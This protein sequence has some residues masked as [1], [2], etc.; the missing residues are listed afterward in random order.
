MDLFKY[1]ATISFFLSTS[2]FIEGLHIN[3]DITNAVVCRLGENEGL[4]C[5]NRAPSPLTVTSP[6]CSPIDPSMA[7]KP[8]AQNPA[9]HNSIEHL[10]KLQFDRHI[11]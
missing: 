1:P 2:V 11:F 3:F 10:P 6:S 9:Q 8:R 5:I 7:R 4:I